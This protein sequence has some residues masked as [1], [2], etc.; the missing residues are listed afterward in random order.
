[1][2]NNENIES[3]IP[4]DRE[5]RMLQAFA[6]YSRTV[7]RKTLTSVNIDY[8]TRKSSIVFVL[9]PEW[10]TTFPPYNLA[11]LSAITKH[12]GYKTQVFDI[13]QI[14]FT[15][16]KSWNLNFDPW[17]PAH[18]PK[19]FSEDYYNYIHSH[20]ENLLLEYV[21]KIVE[22][23]PTAVGFTLYDCNK[24]P[25]SWFITE[26][27]KRLPN[28]ITIAGGGICNKSELTISDQFDYIAAGEGEQLILDIMNDI[29][30]NGKPLQTKRI[31]QELDQRIN[32]DT[33]PLPDY[34]HFDLN[35]YDMP[36][37]VAM[38]LSRGCIAK[39]TFCDETHYW[40]YRDR[41]ASRV[42][43]EIIALN[44]TGVT[45][46]WFIDS[47]V[48][49]NLN[50]F[51]GILKGIIAS[52]LRI[53]WMGQ[54]RIDKR[55]DFEFFKDIR[56]SG[57]RV[58]S[59]GVE[60]GSN[61]V[62]ADMAKGITREDIEQNFNDA[63]LNNISVGCMLIIGFPTETPQ[64][65]YET[66]T[67]LSRTRNLISF[68]SSGISGLTIFED[69]IIGQRPEDYKVA[70]AHFGN[71]WMTEDLKNTRIHRLIRMKTTAIFLEHLKNDKNIDFSFR[72]LT[73]YKIEFI[74]PSIQHEIDYEL[75][76][77]NV[78]NK[79]T[80]NNFIDSIFCEIWPLLRIMWRT[81][82]GYKISIPFR[83][84]YDTFQ[85]SQWLG[86]NF[87]AD[88]NFE[89]DNDG[90]WTADFVIDFKQDETT[91]WT[92]NLPVIH[93]ETKPLS[94]AKTFAIKGLKK[95]SKTFQERLD[96]WN[97]F[98]KLDLTFSDIFTGTGKW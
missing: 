26:L 24:E 88:F 15:Q 85:F 43:D 80:G 52:N 91:K 35:S 57:I 6:P 75:F 4:L 94:R 90:N 12:A 14:A 56:D 22:I 78:C 81:R 84:E 61:K 2:E 13:N 71:A 36:N 74:D 41:M 21:A 20:I 44:E 95:S 69:T 65:Y 67:L 66:L 45:M 37:A 17:H 59:F 3:L 77:F 8:A 53:E 48:N 28:I 68:I 63:Y 9:I 33:L 70:A 49:G 11:R 60:A 98:G 54:A 64:D 5:T 42:L 34:S 1:M 10:A 19:W 87:T 79:N 97:E 72:K 29:E 73:D 82:G 86:C 27:K 7:P 32:L 92:G 18:M 55:M 38:E 62:L 25:V 93:D 83:Q 23:N 39:C 31:V 58:L 46:F 89:I 30:T 40:K 96:Q 50:E 51:R 76:D 47:L 16:H